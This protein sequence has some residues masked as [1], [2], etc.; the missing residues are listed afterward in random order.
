MQNSAHL[1]IHPQLTLVSRKPISSELYSGTED[2]GDFQN[3]DEMENQGM[4]GSWYIEEDNA[5]AFL[6]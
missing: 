5:K 4:D 1:R 6:S 2:F 3:A